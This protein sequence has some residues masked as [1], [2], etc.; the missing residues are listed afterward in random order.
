MSEN[1]YIEK[2][3]EMELYNKMHNEAQMQNYIY[4][5]DIRQT[6]PNNNDQQKTALALHINHNWNNMNHSDK[7]LTLSKCYSEQKL[8]SELLAY[9]LKHL[10]MSTVD[11]V[12]IHEFEKVAKTL[13]KRYQWKAGGF[14]IEDIDWI[15]H[16]KGSK[17]VLGKNQL[18]LENTIDTVDFHSETFTDF[19]KKIGNKLN[20]I[21]QNIS[22]S[23]KYDISKTDS[24]TWIIIKCSDNTKKEKKIEL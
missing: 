20:N 8:D 5:E 10:N 16:K 13:L 2:T 9:E 24:L 23:I 18:V 21:A 4:S 19:M 11:Y 7:S 3:K 15:S 6:V 17:Y 22:V 12:G 1:R 14:Y